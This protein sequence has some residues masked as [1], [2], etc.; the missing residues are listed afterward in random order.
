M[1][2]KISVG[3]ALTI[4][5]IAII[6]TVLVTTA[7]TMSIFS[8]I[9]SDVPQREAMYDSIAEVDNIIRNNYVGELS[10]DSIDL[11]ISSGYVESLSE[12]IN[13]IMTEEEYSDYKLR[14]SGT[15]KDGNS[16]ASIIYKKFGN[17]GYIKISDFTDN[18]ADEFSEAYK[19]LKDNSVTGL[20]IDVR[21]TESINIASAVAVIDKIV[22]LATQGT[23]AIATSVG[24]NGE[25]IEIFSADSESIDVPVSVIVNE[26]TSGAG[27]LLACDI[28]DYGIGTVVGKTT[29]GV[30]TYQKVFELNNGGA[31]VITAANILPYTSDSYE[32]TGVK[33]NYEADGSANPDDLNSDTQF[34]QAYA[35]V[36][37]LQR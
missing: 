37:S 21:D 3:L 5:M 29:M 6:A 9:V 22:P 31:I 7:V 32:G 34:L 23:Q 2:K 35:S 13:Y 25:A 10:Q 36:S 27:E 17:A 28:R 18:T 12:G 19:V 30:C 33:P 26:N 15:D 24:K 4:A 1:H 8:D 16:V 20:V 14:Q 11:G